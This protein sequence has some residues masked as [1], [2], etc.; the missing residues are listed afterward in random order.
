ML[1]IVLILIVQTVNSNS[2]WGTL[3]PNLYFA[4]KEKAVE[5]S[6]L[7]LAWIVKDW[8]TDMLLVRHAYQYANLAE[9]VQ[10]YY[11]AHDGQNFARQTIIDTDYNAR[12]LVDFLQKKPESEPADEWLLDYYI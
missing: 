3:K 8:R 6:V 2:S 10:A 12:F 11:T 4:V 9:N 5:Q 7:G 1:I